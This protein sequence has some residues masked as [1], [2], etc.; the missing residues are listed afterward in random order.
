MQ[1]S[2]F[3]CSITSPTSTR[4]IYPSSLLLLFRY[5]SQHFNST[6]PVFFCFQIIGILRPMTVT[7]EKPIS[8]YRCLHSTLILR[9]WSSYSCYVFASQL[10]PSLSPLSLF[11]NASLISDLDSIVSVLISVGKGEFYIV[12]FLQTVYPLLLSIRIL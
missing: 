4:E 12:Y 3:F 2:S 9:G 1:L 7:M 11:S 8:R 6:A 10:L 5:Y